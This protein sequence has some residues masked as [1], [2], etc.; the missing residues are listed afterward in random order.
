MSVEM[1][2]EKLIGLWFFS[3]ILLGILLGL[4][5]SWVSKGIKNL[6]ENE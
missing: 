6:V 2:L 5:L 1:D 4:V 3:G